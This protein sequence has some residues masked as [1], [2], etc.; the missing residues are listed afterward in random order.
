LRLLFHLKNLDRA[1]VEKHL[2]EQKKKRSNL[3]E[4]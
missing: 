1:I 3:C 2:K 4:R